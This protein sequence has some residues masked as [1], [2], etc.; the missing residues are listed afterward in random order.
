MDRRDVPAAVT[1]LSDGFNTVR[2]IGPALGSIVV[3]S[4]GACDGSRPDR[5]PLSAASGNH[6]ALQMNGSDRRNNFRTRSVGGLL[7]GSGRHT[8]LQTIRLRRL[9]RAVSN[10]YQSDLVDLGSEVFP[11]CGA[12]V[13][14]YP[15]FGS[16]RSL[17]PC[18]SQA[19]K[20]RGCSKTNYQCICEP[21]QE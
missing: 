1:L 12:E 17:H 21:C 13:G 3:A 4:S 8:V 16:P 15:S 19:T 11:K 14:P 5:T 20:F 6:M 18:P 9:I 2:T 10:W 7:P